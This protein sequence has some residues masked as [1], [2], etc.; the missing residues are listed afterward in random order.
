MAMNSVGA[1]LPAARQLVQ[2][3]RDVGGTVPESLTRILAASELLSV[4]PAATDPV[5]AILN[6]AAAG[7]LDESRLADLVADA[8]AASAVRDYRSQVAGRVE[9]GLLDRFYKALCAGA[10]DEILDSLRPLFGE[11]AG[12][13]TEATD[14]VDVSVDPAQLALHGDSEEIKA[15][16]SIRPLVTVL[17]DISSIARRFGPRSVDFAVLDNPPNVDDRGVLDEAV[18]CS[19]DPD[20]IQAGAVFRSRSADIRSCPW[21]R[22]APRL[23][24]IAEATE[25]LRGWAEAAF[26]QTVSNRGRGRFDNGVFVAEP[27]PNPYAVPAT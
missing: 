13:L 15:Y 16:R 6:A 23:H 26:D 3:V 20:L 12:K 27:I 21:L 2:S 8:A 14:L 22:T 19:A 24:T 10:A 9:A 7:E 17:D 1:S 25:R 18:M 4:Q 11:A 5:K